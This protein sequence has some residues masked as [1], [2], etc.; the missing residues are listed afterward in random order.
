MGK[1]YVGVD[2]G[3]TNVR[4][5]IVG[6]RDKL[7]VKVSSTTIKTGPAEALATQIIH[8]IEHGLKELEI[9]KE[10]IGGIGTSSAGPFVGGESLAS[11][12][13]C[14]FEGENDWTIIPY[15]QEL[16]K[17]FGKGK[18]YA[19][20]N[21]CVS[22]VKAEHLFGAGHGYNHCVF[23]T[24][25]T[26]VGTGIISNGILL[27]GKGK[28]AGHFGHLIVEKDG[29]QCGCG[30]KGC[31][32]TFI[33]GGNIAR[34]AKDAG[35]LYKGSNEFTS[36]EVF[37]LYYS[38]D[39]IA[40]QII[41]ETIEYMA[42]LFINVINATDTDRLIVGGS[43]FLNHSELLIPN[44]LDYIAEHSMVVLSE[45]VQLL[46]PELGNFVGD[47]AG[48]SLVLP[49]SWIERWQEKKPWK[50]GVE[51]EIQLTQDEAMNFKP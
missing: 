41:K 23:I 12:N 30:Q 35:L 37:E 36:K 42:I 15:L 1:F 16:K 5:M 8:M 40:E 26:G 3:G 24:I 43:V 29:Y 11:P 44:V 27:E 34:R 39:P 45:G 20:G 9:S 18:V 7:L 48:L 49:E 14:G 25:S 21:D 50:D 19:L 10:Q 6:Q 46:L 31:I 32:E 2:I 28:N 47:I 17:Y 38:N 51:K 13:I 22:A 33:S 4:V